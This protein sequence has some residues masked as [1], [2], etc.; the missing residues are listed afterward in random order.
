MSSKVK[1]K[2]D[3]GL[4]DAITFKIQDIA[5]GGSGVG[6]INDI[7]C[8]IK[9][10][11][12]EEIVTARI[13]RKKPR[14]LEATLLALEQKSPLRIEPPCP[15]FL[16][17]GGCSYQHLEY[18]HQL[19]IKQKQLRDALERIA[20]IQNPPVKA[21]IPSPEALHYRNRI[22]VHVRKGALGFFVEKGRDLIEVDHCL[23]ASKEVNKALAQ[24]KSQRPMDGDYLLGEKERYG[25][26]RQVNNA[27]ATLLLE[28]VKRYAIQNPA[29]I[30]IDA[31]C[32]AG[33]FSHALA[34]SFSQVIG[35]ERSQSSIAL[36]CQGADPNELFEEGSVEEVLPQKLLEC[37]SAK[38]TLI[39]DPP[40]EGLSELVVLAILNNP[41]SS[42]I[43]VS[44]NPATLARDLKRL[45]SQYQLQESTPLDM[46][47]QTAEIESINFLRVH[48]Y[49]H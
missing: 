7:A 30:L 36:A 23:I 37:S 14:F 17:C 44:C 35:I 28:E 21:M 10:V 19:N 40:S 43:Y 22:T 1:I 46:F 38:T 45:S 6:R 48:N 20:G 26:F 33:F 3:I 11:I 18:S 24:L 16:K 5:F 12:D 47:P 49:V 13:I 15:Y 4:G 2:P 29:E 9:G 31:Y 27:V 32:G 34:T 39:L 41:P 25:G 8:F 42:M